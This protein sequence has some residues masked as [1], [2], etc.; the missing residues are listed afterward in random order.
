MFSGIGRRLYCLKLL[1][2]DVVSLIFHNFW[3]FPA[4]REQINQM[5]HLFKNF[6][7]VGGRIVLAGVGAGAISLDA[8]RRR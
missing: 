2:S 5:L 1:S 6:S 7:I 4:G 3:A 8:K